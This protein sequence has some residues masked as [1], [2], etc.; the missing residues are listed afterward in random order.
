MKIVIHYDEKS[1]RIKNGQKETEDVT[2]ILR[3]SLASKPQQNSNSS[4]K[5]LGGDEKNNGRVE[6]K[7]ENAPGMEK[8]E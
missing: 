4:S 8:K 1:D 2:A 3:A 6:G 7:D 5:G